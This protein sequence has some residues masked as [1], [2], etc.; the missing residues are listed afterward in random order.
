MGRGASASSS[1]ASSASAPG[2]EYALGSFLLGL[3]TKKSG[4]NGNLRSLLNTWLKES[5]DD[6]S[7][8]KSSRVSTNNLSARQTPLSNSSS[9]QSFHSA[10]L[11]EPD[12]TLTSVDEA[13][14][15]T[16]ELP[17]RLSQA[18]A[19]STSQ[20]RPTDGSG[21]SEP[22]SRRTTEGYSSSPV[23]PKGATQTGKWG[24]PQPV[25]VSEDAHEPVIRQSKT[26]SPPVAKPWA[27]AR[28]V[29][30]TVSRSDLASFAAS[31]S[32]SDKSH[33]SD[34]EPSAKPLRSCEECHSAID[35]PVFMLH[36]RAYCCQRHRLAAYHK[37]EERQQRMG[38]T[39]LQPPS[40]AASG[41]RA[42]FASWI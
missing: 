30:Q 17:S 7:R 2:E 23:A 18:S 27:E 22:F 6:V 32:F 24:S 19:A 29:P 25:C 36:D 42:S 35:G 37:Q 8:I 9:R 31:M 33:A 34:S 4:T 41:L 3:I 28:C 5:L 38:D 21:R 39:S 26:A 12:L 16:S 40:Q 11:S 13:F 1:F 20:A 10:N 15:G 14:N